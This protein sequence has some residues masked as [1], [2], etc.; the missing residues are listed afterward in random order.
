[1]IYDYTV[2]IGCWRCSR[3]P[4]G[5]DRIDDFHSGRVGAVGALCLGDPGPAANHSARHQQRQASAASTHCVQTR[6]RR[7][8]APPRSNHHRQPAAAN[9]PGGWQPTNQPASSVKGSAPPAR[10]HVHGGG[11]RPANM[12][13]TSPLPRMLT[14]QRRLGGNRPCR[15]SSQ[16]SCAHSKYTHYRYIYIAYVYI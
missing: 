16:R 13:P 7:S 11:P 8:C 3:R 1:M 5:N 4:L 10:P 2:P 9:N 14:G 15:T 12:Y 6:R